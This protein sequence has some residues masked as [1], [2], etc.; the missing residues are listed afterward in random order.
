MNAPLLKPIK[1]DT[2]SFYTFPSAIE[3]LGLNVI[4]SG[5]KFRFSK[6][7][8]LN[9]PNLGVQGDNYKNNLVLNA[10]PGAFTQINGTKPQNILFIESLQNYCFNL[11]KLVT[12]TNTYNSNLSST[13]SERVFWKW[14]KELGGLRFREARVG[15]ES[16]EPGFFVEE[17]ES[18]N[19][20]R[21]VKFVGEINITNQV[22]INNE[23]YLEVYTYIPTTAGSQNIILFKQKDDNNFKPGQYF[24]YNPI[25]PLEKEYI[26]GRNNTTMHPSGL[27]VNA[28][29]DSDGNSFNILDPWGAVAD[30]YVFDHFTN[31][32][33][34][35]SNPNFYW[36][37]NT[38]ISNTYFT[39]TIS[40]AKNDIFKI[41]SPNISVEWKR[42]RLDCVGIEFDLNKYFVSTQLKHKN[43]GEYSESDYV[44]SEFEFNAICLFYDLYDD[45]QV[46]ATNLF[47][48][49]FLDDFI[50]SGNSY[51]I[52][53]IKKIK[54]NEKIAKYGNSFS[55]RFN[56]KLDLNTNDETFY[57]V[58]NDYSPFSLELYIDSLNNLIK[59]SEILL[60]NNLKI[61]NLKE[62]VDS[63]K[64]IFLSL[65]SNELLSKRI[66]NLEEII[67]N[68]QSIFQSNKNLINLITNLQNQIIE[69]AK[70]NTPLEIQYNIDVIEPLWGIEISKS[71]SKIL[72]ENKRYAFNFSKNPKKY[73]PNDFQVAP[74]EYII[75][76]DISPEGNMYYSI[77]FT[78]PDNVWV[79]DKDI[80]ILLK[81][82]FQWKTGQLL[83]IV[84]NKPIELNNPGGNYFI[85]FFTDFNNLLNL[86]SNYM[87][88]I[89]IIRWTDIK[90][91]NNKPV[92]EIICLDSKKFEFDI[93]IF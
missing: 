61:K 20:Q 90:N 87:K 19:Y 85:E 91:S 6:F 25:N 48:V 93:N 29:Y 56:F 58:I 72:L 86:Q 89:S 22:K 83:R 59:S 65:P 38:P 14:L 77:N 35:S 41:E 34:D 43:W 74:F 28:Y 66:E 52:P 50:Q 79:A 31:T 76:L 81:D 4:E 9:I 30:F 18:D 10:Q 37:F 46:F 73:L 78:N 69:L 47:G 15:E 92:I 36:W 17:D 2:G 64:N 62:E 42:S 57:K 40:E 88:N 53:K 75:E 23:N 24:T 54:S 84:F 7:V 80:K 12:S 32:W 3:D 13:I 27:S 49:I 21:I 82:N 60:E 16:T 33:I 45:E 68:S 8:T 39:D 55:Y 67:E 44:N 70:G 63:L 11:E 5:K 51:Y 26:V 1:K 71:N